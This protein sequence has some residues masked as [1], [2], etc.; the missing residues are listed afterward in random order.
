M[1]GDLDTAAAVLFRKDE[2]GWFAQDSK[3]VRSDAKLTTQKTMQILSGVLVQRCYDRSGKSRGLCEVSRYVYGNGRKNLLVTAGPY[4]GET[5]YVV[6]N[7]VRFVS[8]TSTAR[9]R[10]KR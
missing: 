5:E 3:G 7:S 8:T 4:I 2:K 10:P 6:L 9:T 1:D